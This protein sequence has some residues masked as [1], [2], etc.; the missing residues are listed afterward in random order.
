MFWL[1]RGHFSAFWLPRGHFSARFGSQE[2]TLAR[3][4]QQLTVHITGH[5][6]SFL[7]TRFHTLKQRRRI[8]TGENFVPTSQVIST[9]DKTIQSERMIGKTCLHL[10]LPLRALVERRWKRT[11][12]SGG[13]VAH[14]CMWTVTIISFKNKH[15]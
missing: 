13:C 12:P 2:G 10:H 9:G 1:P 8:F 11:A 15:T 4:F 6:Q 7:S 14:C 5:T 3:D